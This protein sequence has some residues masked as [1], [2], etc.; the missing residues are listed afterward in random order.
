MKNW[1]FVLVFSFI[2]ISCKK[3]NSSNTNQ[4]IEVYSQLF[5]D[6][7]EYGTAENINISDLQDEFWL[8]W[9]ANT[10]QTETV[11]FLNYKSPENGQIYSGLTIDRRPSMKAGTNTS[12][13]LNIGGGTSMNGYVTVNLTKFGTNTNDIWEGSFSG[14]VNVYYSSNLSYKENVTCT[15][16]FRVVSK[17][18][19]P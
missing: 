19:N 11:I 9:T 17:Q 15:G 1:I 13:Y 4:T 8:D 7:K 18:F 6:G 5:V 10:D 16:K 12:C 3:D 2:L 14:K